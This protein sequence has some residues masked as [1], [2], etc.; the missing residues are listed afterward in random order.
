MR[1]PFC[2]DLPL[3]QA[4]SIKF[5]SML[6]MPLLIREEGLS[7]S[8]VYDRDAIGICGNSLSS[9]PVDPHFQVY[10]H[11]Y[12]CCN[13]IMFQTEWEGHSFVVSLYI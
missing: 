12:P 3:A 6:R 13:H 2:K 1:V 7:S 10:I 4:V 8:C 5:S 9:K 11:Q